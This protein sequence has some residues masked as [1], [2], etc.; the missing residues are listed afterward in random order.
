MIEYTAK[1]T[2]HKFIRINNH[3]QTDV[4]E[5]IGVYSTDLTGAL[6]FK[7]GFFFVEKK[8]DNKYIGRTTC[9]GHDQW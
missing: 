7:E 1:L 3:E 6:V 8:N 5:Y 9:S 4:S 2:G